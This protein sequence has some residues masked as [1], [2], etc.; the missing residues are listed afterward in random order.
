MFKKI[1]AMVLALTLCFALAACGKGEAETDESPI[2][3]EADENAPIS[4]P[5]DEDNA[6]VIKITMPAFLYES[7]T[8]E[9]II[10]IAQEAGYSSCL[11]NEDGSVTYTLSKEKYNEMVDSFKAE[12]EGYAKQYLEGEDAVESFKD[13]TFNDDYSEIDFL[14]DAELFSEDQTEHSFVFYTSAATYQ[15]FIGVDDDNISVTVKFVNS[16]NNEVIEEFKVTAANY[17]SFAG[18][19]RDE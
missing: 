10:Y 18:G 12:M 17:S 5:E 19:V 8:N 6:E 13:I 7:T 14:V 11:I 15:A 16:E 3:I 4:N 2:D 9:E 1:T